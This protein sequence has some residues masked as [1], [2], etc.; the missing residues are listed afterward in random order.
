MANPT[1]L[2]LAM[3]PGRRL[4]KEKIGI[5]IAIPAK[6]EALGLKP[7]NIN[8]MIDTIEMEMTEV[9]KK[10]SHS[11]DLVDIEFFIFIPRNAAGQYF[12]TIAWHS[13]SMSATACRLILDV[14]PHHAE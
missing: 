6:T 11:P 1:P 7:S 14:D 2:T 8:R 13:A 3:P 5:A 10:S 9:A 4:A 12:Q